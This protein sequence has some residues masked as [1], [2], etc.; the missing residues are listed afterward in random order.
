YYWS[1]YGYQDYFEPNGVSE[2]TYRQY[3]EDSH[4]AENYFLHLYGEG[5]SKEIASDKVT[6]TTLEKFILVE[7]LQSSYD[8][9]TDDQK[10]AR[11]Q[12]MEENAKLINEGQKTFDQA[13][14]EFNTSAEEHDHDDDKDSS[15]TKPKYS[16]ANVFGAKDTVYESEYFDKFKDYPVDQAKVYEMEDGSG[17]LLV[18]KRDL[19]SDKYYMENLDPIVRHLIADEEFDK[20]I[21]KFIKTLKVDKN[22]Y[23]LKR[24]KVKKI[25]EL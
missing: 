6:S 9:L 15:E 5:G 3:T 23:A 1:D 13:Y 20:E 11:K 22:N 10:T 19:K 16:H 14:H 17:C 18:V 25:K 7:I 2:T 24:L 21:D 4:Y 8:Q 12:L